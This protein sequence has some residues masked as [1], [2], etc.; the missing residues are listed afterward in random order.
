L[1]S[2]KQSDNIQEHHEIEHPNISYHMSII[3]SPFGVI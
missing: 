2:V 1:Q 3:T